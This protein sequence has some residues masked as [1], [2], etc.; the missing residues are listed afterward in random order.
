[1]YVFS[2]QVKTLPQ[3]TEDSGAENAND[4]MAESNL[5][6]SSYLPSSVNI[7][8][9]KKEASAQIDFSEIELLD[10]L[11]LQDSLDS[12][13]REPIEPKSTANSKEQQ[14]DVSSPIQT[15]L[16]PSLDSV[17]LQE[18]NN[19]TDSILFAAGL[20]KKG[21]KTDFLPKKS[22]DY[23]YKFP[24]WEVT[25][26]DAPGLIGLLQLEISVNQANYLEILPKW[27]KEL[28]TATLNI[29]YF[30]PKHQMALPKVRAELEKSYVF[31]LP[32]GTLKSLR[33]KNLT[34]R[35]EEHDKKVLP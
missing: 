27:E 31:I 32:Q 16:E 29:F 14:E 3:T 24:E 21:K 4:T 5:S 1:L 23:W 12:E 9:L 7:T 35:V 22:G 34:L 25:W 15:K 20:L 18:K 19:H 26:R 17:A 2:T 11:T 6:S 8:F 13:P 28:K 30:T 33:V 10:S